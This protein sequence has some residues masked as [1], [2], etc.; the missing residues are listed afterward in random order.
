MSLVQEQQ[1]EQEIDQRELPYSERIDMALNAWKQGNG[2][3]S[4]KKAAKQHGVTY[5]TLQARTKGSNSRV[6]ASQ[7]RQRLSVQEE[8]ALK[9]W[10]LQLGAWGWPPLISQ[11]YK[12]ASKL[13]KAKGDMEPLGV[14]WPQHFLSRHPNLRSRFV[15]SLD[16][17]RLVAADPKIIRRY[18]ELFRRKKAEKD[19]H[20]DDV[21]NIDEKEVIIKVIIKVRIVV[22]REIK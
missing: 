19:I 7:A 10:I 1:V 18:F 3:I 22:D 14:N 20:D 16:K 21:Y 15:P 13:L 12:M 5:S 6:S 9:R 2:T 8:E 4:L 17:E 11:V